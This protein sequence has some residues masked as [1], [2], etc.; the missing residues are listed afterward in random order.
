MTLKMCTLQ[1]RYLK[2]TVDCHLTLGLHDG[3]PTELTAYS[4]SDWGHD[5]DNHCSIAGYVFLLG[6]ST[7]SWSSKKHV[8]VATSSVDSEYQAS[9][10]TACH[11]LWLCH[12]LIELGLDELETLPTTIFIDN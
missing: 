3:N 10:M 6:L 2:G 8:T 4:D 5:I 1:L 9:S 7:I 12:L 11:G